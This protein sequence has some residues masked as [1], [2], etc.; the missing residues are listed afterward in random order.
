MKGG[1]IIK[2]W[3]AWSLLACSFT[4]SSQAFKVVNTDKAVDV[5]FEMA[6]GIGADG[7][8]QH[9]TLKK[10]A[11]ETIEATLNGASTEAR[12]DEQIK[13]ATEHLDQH[14]AIEIGV[15]P[16]APDPKEKGASQKRPAFICKTV[17]VLAPHMK[18][19]T[20][21]QLTF[22]IDVQNQSIKTSEGS[23]VKCDRAL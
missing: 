8:V 22:S 21:D 18:A 23:V 20:V 10:G 15:W 1:W 3:I 11:T 7:F 9:Q 6:I 13:L 17:Y 16:L 14:P 12:I 5:G 2:N 4:G 19:K